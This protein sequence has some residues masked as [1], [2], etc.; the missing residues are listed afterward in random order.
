MRI[1]KIF[2]DLD[3]VIRDW[4][5]GIFRQFKL[6]PILVTEWDTITKYVCKEH[7]ISENYFWELQDFNF[8]YSLKSYSWINDVL[9]LLP[10][11]KTCILTSPT[12]T[13]AGG[14]QRWIESN[15]PTFFKKR[16]YLIGPAKHFC[17][18]KDALL[19][20]DSDMHIQNFVKAGGQSI[21][22]PQPW[23]NNK[24]VIDDKVGFLK[25]RLNM[26]DI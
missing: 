2:L 13:S 9:D 15:L 1:N 3:G 12:L 17:A 4:C 14:T 11:N 16:Q 10:I 5:G 18:S 7:G 6:P 23:N 20:D 22:F 19:I 26:Y 21:L 8:W 24:D 25:M